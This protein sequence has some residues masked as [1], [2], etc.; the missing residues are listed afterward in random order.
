MRDTQPEPWSVC[1]LLARRGH[2]RRHCNEEEGFGTLSGSSE[3]MNATA[4]PVWV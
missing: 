4:V 1:E 2:Q 3:M